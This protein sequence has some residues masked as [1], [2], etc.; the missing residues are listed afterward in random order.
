M[1]C[2]EDWGYPEGL[3]GLWQ[4]DK[5]IFYALHRRL[6]EPCLFM[7]ILWPYLD[8]QSYMHP[9]FFRICN[10]FK[11]SRAKFKGATPMGLQGLCNPLGTPPGGGPLVLYTLFYGV[12]KTEK[13]GISSH[14]MAIK[15]LGLHL[16]G[17]LAKYG[18]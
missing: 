18:V 2:I 3:Q 10:P 15:R 8:N 6:G 16:K 1:L 17:L 5:S 9:I 7:A 4:S 13:G 12:Y 11:L 14:N